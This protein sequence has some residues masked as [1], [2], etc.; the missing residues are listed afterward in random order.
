MN[1]D[2]LVK[3]VSRIINESGTAGEEHDR[4]Q[5]ELDEWA[6]KKNYTNKYHSLSS[7]AMP[8]VLR[9]NDSNEYLFLGDAKDFKNEDSKNSDTLSRIQGYF[10]EFAKLLGGDGY[11]GGILAIATNS[12]EAA[13]DWVSTLNTLASSARIS[14]K[15]NGKPN[16]KVTEINFGK[17][18][19]V[20]W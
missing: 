10:N 18:W 8:D 11:K 4:L 3:I 12:S 15:D 17:T 1:N 16:F 14:A 5:S 13:T 19:I 9:S 7:G 20:A 6:Q 2:S